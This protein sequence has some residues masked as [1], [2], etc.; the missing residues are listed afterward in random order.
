MLIVVEWCRRRSRVA[1][2]IATSGKR[3]AQSPYD[4]LEVRTI[5]PFSYR[6]DTSS[7][8]QFAAG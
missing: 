5:E 1:E 3:L 7:N 4:L 8:S 2:A 6:R